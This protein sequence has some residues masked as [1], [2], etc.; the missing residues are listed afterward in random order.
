M[1]FSF[2]FLF[3]NNILLV[4]TIISA[5]VDAILDG[6]KKKRSNIDEDE[7]LSH[8]HQT[9][10]LTE[11]TYI[12]NETSEKENVL[13]NNTNVSPNGV[14]RM[15]RD[16][17]ELSSSEFIKLLHP[18]ETDEQ[19]SEV[20]SQESDGDTTDGISGSGQSSGSGEL[21]TEINDQSN[22][23]LSNILNN[24]FYEK[25]TTKD[26]SLYQNRSDQNEQFSFESENH[27]SSGDSESRSD[28]L[29]SSSSSS[30]SGMFCMLLNFFY[31]TFSCLRC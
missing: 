10:S 21:I 19:K 4:R 9:P 2:F 27:D 14:E 15:K 28:D 8:N 25:N 1:E 30:S 23:P 22:K 7:F 12:V 24:T 3:Y 16:D 29:S 18:E 6:D 17:D 13:N 5:I 11:H 26:K 31:E 20:L